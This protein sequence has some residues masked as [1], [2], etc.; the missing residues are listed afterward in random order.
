MYLRNIRTTGAE[1]VNIVVILQTYVLKVLGFNLKAV[2]ERTVGLCARF[3][4]R[5]YSGNVGKML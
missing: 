3:M 1:Q 2:T 5:F 4:A